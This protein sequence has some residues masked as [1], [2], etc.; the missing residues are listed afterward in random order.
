MASAPPN[1]IIVYHYPFSPYARRVLWYFQLQGIHY[2]QC[3]Q[4]PTLPRPTLEALNVNYRR[5]PL[6]SIG[7]T[8]YCDSRLILRKL[9]TRFGST[10]KSS[11]PKLGLAPL[12]TP[13][14]KALANLFERWTGDGGVFARATKLIPLDL[15]VMKDAKFRED[16]SSFAGGKRS[17]DPEAMRQARPE[18]LAGIREQLEWLES[19]L[20]SDGREWVLATPKASIADI[21]AIWLFDWLIEMPGALPAEWSKQFP[22][23]W[24]WVARFRAVLKETRNLAPK[25]VTFKPEETVS[26]VL[27]AQFAPVLDSAGPAGQVEWVDPADSLGLKAGDSVT[28]WPIDSGMTHKDQG[29]LVRLSVNEVIIEKEVKGSTIRVSMPRWNFRIIKSSS[30]SKI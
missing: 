27:S 3:V 26:Y 14:Q 5:I 23:V 25:A 19:G 10:P 6:M 17:W 18:A 9:E 30:A 13:D 22:R 15:P 28:V 29:K 12:T 7:R 21:E 11:N 1:E 20:L 2:G 24:A 8:V 4:P 16:R